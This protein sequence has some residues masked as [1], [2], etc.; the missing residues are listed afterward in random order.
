M[1]L[2]AVLRSFADAREQGGDQHRVRVHHHFDVEIRVGV[3]FQIFSAEFAQ[4]L[5]QRAV[6]ERHEIRGLES[7]IG[8][9]IEKNVLHTNSSPFKNTCLT[10]SQG[11]TTTK[12]ACAPRAM[13]PKSG[14]VE[15]VCRVGGGKAENVHGEQ[16]V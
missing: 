16:P 15:Q 12:L 2:R 1:S 6:F 11:S 10:C 5:A 14:R 13:R 7:K 3:L 8:G 4:A 9:G